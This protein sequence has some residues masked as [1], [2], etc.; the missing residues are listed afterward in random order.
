MGT[1]PM[2]WFVG[3]LCWAVGPFEPSP[4]LLGRQERLRGFGVEGLHRVV[5]NGGWPL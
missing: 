4:G 5:S 3:S 2:A 1:V